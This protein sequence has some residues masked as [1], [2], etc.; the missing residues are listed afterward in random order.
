MADTLPGELRWEPSTVRWEVR[1]VE[2]PERVD[3]PGWP[4]DPT[5]DEEADA[6]S[7]LTL[8]GWRCADARWHCPG[9]AP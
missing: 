2:C 5:G 3:F 4:T 6:A 1:C 8:L 9:C 7:F